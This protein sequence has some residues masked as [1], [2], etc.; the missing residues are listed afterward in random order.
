MTAAVIHGKTTELTTLW[1]RTPLLTQLGL[2]D[3]NQH[4]RVR[5]VPDREVVIMAPI[6]VLDCFFFRTPGH[7]IVV[8]FTPLDRGQGDISDRKRLERHT[9]SHAEF[10]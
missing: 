6:V 5:A 8:K 1:S 2:P 9:N 10:A 7:H 4:V 3:I